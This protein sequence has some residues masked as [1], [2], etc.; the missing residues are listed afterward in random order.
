LAKQLPLDSW[1]HA[2][3]FGSFRNESALLGFLAHGLRLSRRAFS[4]G[5][6]PEY[7]ELFLEH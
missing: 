1:H 2:A 3:K 6:L 5:N 4:H 7:A